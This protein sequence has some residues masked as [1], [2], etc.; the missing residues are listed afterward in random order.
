MNKKRVIV[1]IA[2]FILFVAIISI[3]IIANTKKENPEEILKRVYS[4]YRTAKI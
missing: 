2:L 1:V 3:V 4:P